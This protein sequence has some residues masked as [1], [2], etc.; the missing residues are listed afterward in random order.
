MF[1]TEALGCTHSAI[2]YTYLNVLSIMICIL[3]VHTIFQRRNYVFITK[4]TF[5]KKYKNNTNIS[6]VNG[7]MKISLSSMLKQL[8]RKLEYKLSVTQFSF[9]GRKSV[10]S[11]GESIFS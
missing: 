3:F 1:D 4:I 9:P 7:D 2:D 5:Y 8:N 6:K 11:S 10:S